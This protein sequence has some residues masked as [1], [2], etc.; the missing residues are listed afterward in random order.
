ME[1]AE[2]D[3][4]I[5][6]ENLRTSKLYIDS[7]YGER[8]DYDIV[9]KSSET[10]MEAEGENLVI[11]TNINSNMTD[12]ISDFKIT[13]HKHSEDESVDIKYEL[14]QFKVEIKK[15]ASPVKSND[16]T[17]TQF[18]ESNIK[19]RSRISSA[20]E[21][22][23]SV[24]HAYSLNNFGKDSLSVIDDGKGDSTIK[25]NESTSLTNT[26]N[27]PAATSKKTII[28]RK[29]RRFFLK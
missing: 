27:Y 15:K 20:Q 5:S 10:T 17:E 18:N 3:E 6:K 1:N 26:N 12:I 23:D 28:Y 2:R 7:E 21:R 4:E 16:L 19:T 11:S 25:E 14:P 29:F 22:A 24:F 8:T 13:K 9:A